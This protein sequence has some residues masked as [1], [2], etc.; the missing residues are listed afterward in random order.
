MLSSR[1]LGILAF[2]IDKKDLLYDR[3]LLGEGPTLTLPYALAVGG[4]PKQRGFFSPK[5]P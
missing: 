2:Q 5:L 1:L 3:F 4:A